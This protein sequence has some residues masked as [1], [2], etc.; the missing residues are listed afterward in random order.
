MITDIDLLQPFASVTVYDVVPA[1]CV[2]VP[3]PVYGAVP[4]V[5][6]IVTVDVP[7]LH[8]I[9]VCVSAG[10]SKVGSVIV[11]DIDLLQPFAS[12]TVYDV[13]PALC[14]NVPVPVYGAVPPVAL[15]VTVDVPP[16]HA[17]A[18][19]VSAG[20]SKVGSVI[21]TDIDLLQPFASVTVY[22]VVPALCVNVPVPVYGAVPPVAL[23]VT[24]DVPPLHAIAVCVS[25]G[26]SKVGS[27]IVTDIDLLQPFASVT[28]YDVVPA[29]CVNVPVPVYGAVPPVA[30]I[31]TVDV[32]PLHAIAVCVSAGTSKVGSVIV[33]DIDLLQPFASVTVYDVVPAL[34]VNVPVP[35][36]GAVPPVALIVTVDVP[37]LHAIAVCVSAGTSKVGSVIVTDIDLLQPFASVTVYD[38]VPALCVNVPVPVYG[39]VPPVALIVTVDVPPLHAIAVC[40]SAGTSKVGSVIVTDI[41]L[42]QPFASVTVYDVVP[43]LC[44]NV[45]VP[46]YGAVPPVALIV[47]VDVPPLHAIAV[48]VSAGT[49]K[50][51]SVIVT[52]IDLLQPFASVTVYDV[53]PAL[54]VNVPVPVYGAVPPVALIVTVDV[55]PLHAIAVCVSAGTSKVGSVIVTDIDLLQ[56]FASVTVYDVVPA[57]CVNVPVPVYGAVPPVALIVTVDVPPLHA[58]AVCVSAGTSKVGSVIVTDIDLLQPFA[59]VT[60]YDVVPALCVNVPVPVYGAVPPVALIVTVDVPPLHAIAVCVS[61]GTSKVG[62]VIVTDIDLLQPF[63]SVTVYDVVPALCVNVPVP[64]YGAVPPVALIVTVDV[65]PLHAIAVCVS[66]GTSKV[67]SVIVTDIDLLQP[68]AS[69]TV[70]DV[71]PALCVNVPV[72]VY[73][74]VPPVALIVTVDVP[75]LHAIAVCVSAGTSKVGSVIVTD[76][77]LLQPFASVTVYDVVPA[78]C[79]NVPVPVYGAVPPVAL[80]VTV[81]VPPLHAIAVCVSAGTS[82]VGSVIVTDIDLLQPFA[83]VT[84]YD[85]VPALCVNVPV[86]VYGAVPPVA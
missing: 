4:P 19:C 39:A 52:D 71:V 2:N 47:T 32:P 60:V 11:T 41:D 59:S 23:I 54:C 61:A 76:I 57:L 27:V 30:L 50:V 29:L 24:V 72:P 82:K 85:V 16:L 56:P 40:V 48:C 34:C 15:I 74:A 79:V 49:S 14:V 51:G 38:V 83:S 17:I 26:T 28:V 69:V 45:P 55:P 35:V 62:S 7:P 67:G 3:V 86:P 75:P 68:F 43:A 80:I 66:A 5:A 44:V 1:L 13:V 12:V 18:V 64:V 6:L 21:V 37:P 33:T 20:T 10:T 73:G 31:V 58:I 81:D 9:A 78:L 46:V 22:D 53:V 70:Y 36:Y 63:A 8:A 77:D 42:L 84:V 25:A 65:P